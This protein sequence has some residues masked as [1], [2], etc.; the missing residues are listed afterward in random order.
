MLEPPYGYH[1]NDENK[2]DI[3]TIATGIK[4]SV[5]NKIAP[6]LK[7]LGI[8]NHGLKKNLNKNAIILLMNISN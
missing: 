7:E 3:A 1:A 4:T 5:A 8:K 2:E 6:C